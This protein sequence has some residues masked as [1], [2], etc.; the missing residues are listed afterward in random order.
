MAMKGLLAVYFFRAGFEVRCASID[1]SG[2]D[3]DWL[4][5]LPYFLIRYWWYVMTSICLLAWFP[6]RLSEKQSS[7]SSSAAP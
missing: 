5:L 6:D 3:L 1:Y 4:F 7:S 2:K